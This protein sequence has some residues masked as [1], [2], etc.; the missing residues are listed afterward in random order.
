MAEKIKN[1]INTINMTSRVR[2]VTGQDN[3]L[4]Y[5]SMNFNGVFAIDGIKLRRGPNG[6][7]MN[8][9][10]YK[11]KHGQWKDV[12][13]PLSKDFRMEM[14]KN[15]VDEY[16]RTLAQMVEQSQNPAQPQQTNQDSEM[17][18]TQ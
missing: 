13:F 7:N 9:P 17:E 16:Q 4:A 1:S 3:L 15:L 8:M 6:I 10:G 5:A 18:M 14:Q 2:P 12:C 11:D